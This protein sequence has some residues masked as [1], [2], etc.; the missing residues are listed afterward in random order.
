M[1]PKR[2]RMYCPKCGKRSRRRVRI[3]EENWN[4][5]PYYFANVIFNCD[6]GFRNTIT[7]HEW[8]EEIKHEWR[9]N[10]EK[11]RKEHEVWLSTRNDEGCI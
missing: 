3:H 1:V 5:E 9:D 6:C 7:I 2:V 4:C 10:L 8:G 11:M